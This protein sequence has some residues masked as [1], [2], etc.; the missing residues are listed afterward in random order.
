[1]VYKL[2]ERIPL[3]SALLKSASFLDPDVLQDNTRDKLITQSKKLLK[4]I[5]NLSV[6][7]VNS[8]NKALSQFKCLLDNDLKELRLDVIKFVKEDERLDDFYFK[9][10]NAGKYTEFSL[11][12]RFILTLS[13]GRASVEQGLISTMQFRKQTCLPT[14]LLPNVSMT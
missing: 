9:K 1:M 3:G 10:L 4:V 14:Q 8:S 2:F 7:V 12:I 13:H 11:M 6:L 5:M